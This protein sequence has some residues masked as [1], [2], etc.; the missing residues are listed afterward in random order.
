MRLLVS[1]ASYTGIV[2]AIEHGWVGPHMPADF[3]RM[4]FDFGYSNPSWKRIEDEVDPWELAHGMVQYNPANRQLA[5]R[6]HEHTSPEE[7]RQRAR[8]YEFLA[9]K[10][11]FWRHV[12]ARHA[13][14]QPQVPRH[15]GVSHAAWHDLERPRVRGGRYRRPVRRRTRSRSPRPP[16]P[17]AAN[18]INTQFNLNALIGTMLAMQSN[19]GPDL[20]RLAVQAWQEVHK[21]N[22]VMALSSAIRGEKWEA[23]LRLH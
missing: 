5:F 15:C 8:F 23:L 3:A 16:V 17:G 13:P 2:T 22:V 14:R 6:S 12:R 19:V 11:G 4:S 1:L 18:R 20:F 9:A 10:H 21:K 7:K